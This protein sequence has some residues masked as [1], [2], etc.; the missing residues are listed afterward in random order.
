MDKIFCFVGKIDTS[1]LMP[2]CI[3]KAYKP[4]WTKIDYITKL[5]FLHKR[6]KIDFSNDSHTKKV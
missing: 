3:L 6:L 4:N 5:S 1:I 2:E